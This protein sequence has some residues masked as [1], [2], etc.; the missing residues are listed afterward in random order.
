MNDG[1]RST[2]REAEIGRGETQARTRGILIGGKNPRTAVRG[3]N[4]QRGLR[5]RC[6]RDIVATGVTSTP[7]GEGETCRGERSREGD[8][9]LGVPAQLHPRLPAKA[10]ARAPAVSFD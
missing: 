6:L 3:K 7:R 4:A 10:T 2:R 5:D 1:H 8:S 9:P